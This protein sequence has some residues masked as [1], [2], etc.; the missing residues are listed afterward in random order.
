MG[1]CA[2]S[3]EQFETAFFS[4]FVTVEKVTS[5]ANDFSAV[6]RRRG[7]GQ[8]VHR[9]DLKWKILLHGGPDSCPVRWRS[10]MPQAAG[11][12]FLQHGIGLGNLGEG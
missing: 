6:G 7:P 8:V 2:R 4:P 9:T 1:V 12:F 10:G 11:K 5:M 3:A